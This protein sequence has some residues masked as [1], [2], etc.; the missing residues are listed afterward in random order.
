MW[1]AGCQRII[2]KK[3]RKQKEIEAK[4]VA[5]ALIINEIMRKKK[6]RPYKKTNFWIRPLF[7]LWQIHGFCET[8]FLTFLLDEDMFKKYLHMTTNQFEELLNLIRPLI[9]KESTTKNP[10]SAAI[11]LT[12]TLRLVSYSNFNSLFSIVYIVKTNELYA[13]TWQ[14]TSTAYHLVGFIT[15]VTLLGKQCE[16]VWNC[17]HKK[18]L[19][20]PLKTTNWLNITRENQ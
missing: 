10:V 2:E 4:K 8:I 9:F 5:A 18:V 15:A 13:D 17:L 14:V 6:K 16:A 20:L 11:W 1:I 7:Q 12:M 3:Q 19:P